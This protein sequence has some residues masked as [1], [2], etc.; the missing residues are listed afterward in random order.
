MSAARFLDPPTL[1]A[2]SGYSHVA[3]TSGGRTIYLSGQVAL[4][5]EG[6]IVGADDTRLQAEQVFTNLSN[7]LAAVGATFDNVV[8][9][10]Y[11]MIDMADFP[12]VREV[13]DSFVNTSRPP[14]SSAVQV[15]GLVFDWI[16][17][18]VEAIAVID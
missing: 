9:L 17:L 12:S 15:S 13:R 6:Q 1:H 3:E 11:F 5:P 4:S 16:R 8:K 14:A 18:E 2:P 7:A 10:T